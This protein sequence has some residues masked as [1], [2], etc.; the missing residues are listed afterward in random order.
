[1]RDRVLACVIRHNRLNLIAIFSVFKLIFATQFSVWT[2]LP[3]NEIAQ[4]TPQT[5]E[6]IKDQATAA[7]DCFHFS[8]DQRCIA[9]FPRYSIIADWI[10]D[11]V[12]IT[13]EFRGTTDLAP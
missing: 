10:A 5:S 6:F 2:L 12:A 8:P 4:S 9:V 7:G 11:G 3:G 1:M 13:A